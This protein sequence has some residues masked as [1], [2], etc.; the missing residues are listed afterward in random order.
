MTPSA[1]AHPPHPA[2]AYPCC[3]VVILFP[4][5]FHIFFW[6]VILFLHSSNSSFFVRCFV[7]L[8]FW[9]FFFIFFV[10][11]PPSFDET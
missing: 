7:F 9:D 4:L 3:R 10:L 2:C 11:S 8:S 6:V 5:L 1:A